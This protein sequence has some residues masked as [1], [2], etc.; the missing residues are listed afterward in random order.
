MITFTLTVDLDLPDGMSPTDL[1][2]AA[3]DALTHVAHVSR[4]AGLTRVSDDVTRASVMALAKR[5]LPGIA[6][7][8]ARQREE[9]E[10]DA[11]QSYREGYRPHFCIHGTNLWTDYD[12]ICWGCE[13]YGYTGQP[14]RHAVALE[15]ATAAVRALEERSAV[16]GAF[17]A[18][19]GRHASMAL[20]D[21]MLTWAYEPIAS[22]TQRYED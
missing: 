5:L 1:H 4:D 17:Y 9:W 8:Q 19:G 3:I 11:A 14:Q 22:V 2:A 13:E 20:Q 16:S 21:A 15:V 18:A 7:Q 6:R 12:N 10:R